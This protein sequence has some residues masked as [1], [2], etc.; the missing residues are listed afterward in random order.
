MITF[1]RATGVAVSWLQAEM[2]PALTI[3]HRTNQKIQA[4]FIV[5]LPSR[6]VYFLAAG[7]VEPF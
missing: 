6:I 2:Q 5:S 4:A 3:P 1:C 7:G